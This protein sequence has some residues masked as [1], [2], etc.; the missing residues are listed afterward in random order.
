MRGLGLALA[1]AALCASTASIAQ[2]ETPGAVL[3]GS[4]NRA[5]T[6]FTAETTSGPRRV[7]LFTTGMQ[8]PARR[9]VV[10]SRYAGKRIAVACLN[11]SSQDAWKCTAIGEMRATTPGPVER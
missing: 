7:Y 4:V 9:P 5:G 6:E 11:V 3:V 1:G 2:I 8:V 10:L